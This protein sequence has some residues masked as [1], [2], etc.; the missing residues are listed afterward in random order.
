VGPVRA[1]AAR[2]HFDYVYRTEDLLSLAGSRYHA[3]RNYI[4]RF[5]AAAVSE[6]APIGE[7]NLRLCAEFHDR[8][9]ERRRCADD[10]NLL[11]EWEAVKEAL[12]SYGRLDVR[13]GAFLIEGR[14]EAFTFGELLND[15]TVV[16]HIEKANPE[17]P[18]IYAAINQRFL[19]EF[20][21]DVPFV[22]REQDL[23]EPGLRRAK[24][25]YHPHHLVEKH[26]LVLAE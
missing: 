22:N 6:F 11:D 5:G 9:C 10:L 13:G 4:S 17:I 19:R 26:R 25:S 20:W 14:V 7:S 23:G 2:E 18:G 15:N 16:V 24:L 1:E 3:K 12:A 8:W 21:S